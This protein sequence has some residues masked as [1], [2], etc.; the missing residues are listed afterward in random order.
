M[1]NQ[2][3]TD[4][5]VEQRLRTLRIL[6]AVFIATVGLLALVCYLALRGQE[7]T[8]APAD[9]FP[10]IYVFCALGLSVVAASFP[11]KQSYFKRA[12]REQKVDHVQTGII[13]ALAL[14]E[15]AAQ[16]GLVALFVTG[17]HSA[18]LLFLV[19][20]LG[21]LFHFPRREPLLA[22]TAKRAF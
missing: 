12:E 6:W 17:D 11:F 7:T 4:A 22:A 10:L 3:P 21:Q 5:N 20:A 16:F 18:Y 8:P 9:G 13:I 1:M 14:C 15:A 2:T 19:A